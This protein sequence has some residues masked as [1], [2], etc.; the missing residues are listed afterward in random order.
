[1]SL[2]ECPVC[3]GTTFT[4]GGVTTDGSMFF[5]PAPN[6]QASMLDW[7]VPVTALACQTCV[8]IF[9]QCD[10]DQLPQN[11]D[12]A[13]NANRR[14]STSEKELDLAFATAILNSKEFCD[15][16]VRQTRFATFVEKAILLCEEQM[17]TRPRVGPQFWYRHW[18]CK[19]PDG[20]ESETDIMLIFEDVSAN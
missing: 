2:Q 10:P 8:V 7:E 15:W 14:T 17:A 6:P 12:S 11:M 9:I 5:R 3:A 19:L 1:M 20:S 13:L 16:L 4:L 18:W